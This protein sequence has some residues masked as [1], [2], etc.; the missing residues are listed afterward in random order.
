MSQPYEFRT[1]LVIHMTMC[2]AWSWTL[3]IRQCGQ[4]WMTSKYLICITLKSWLKNC[5]QF[6]IFYWAAQHLL[7]WAVW[8][9]R[10]TI[11]HQFR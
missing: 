7:L 3:L 1:K 11:L 9:V 5:G 2:M 4:L 6:C 8:Y 10:A